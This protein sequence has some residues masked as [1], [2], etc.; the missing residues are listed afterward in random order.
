MN[1]FFYIYILHAKTFISVQI[2][3]LNVFSHVNCLYVY[4]IVWWLMH[5]NICLLNKVKIYKN[6]SIE[7]NLITECDRIDRINVMW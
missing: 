2:K 5:Q 6:I 7:L 4:W 3:F 1:V